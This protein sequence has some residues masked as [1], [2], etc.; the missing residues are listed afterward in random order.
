MLLITMAKCKR[1]GF[2]SNSS[3]K[4]L[5]SAFSSSRLVSKVVGINC[6]LHTYYEA[7]WPFLAAFRGEVAAPIP[8]PAPKPIAAPRSVLRKPCWCFLSFT[9]RTSRVLTVNS[10]KRTVFVEHANIIKRHRRANPSNC[11][12]IVRGPALT[13]N[14]IAAS[15]T[16]K[17]A[18]E[19]VF[20]SIPIIWIFSPV[21]SVFRFSYGGDLCGPT[22]CKTLRE[23]GGASQDALIRARIC[24]TAALPKSSMTCAQKPDHACL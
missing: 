16:F 4:G 7:S 22:R 11:L 12:W 6:E 8:A 21:E 17:N 2:L 19:T 9:L 15:E 13:C 1:C 3:A 24:C 14:E 18:P 20:E 5:L 10:Y 23:R